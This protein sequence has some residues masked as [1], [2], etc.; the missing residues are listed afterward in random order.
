VPLALRVVTVLAWLLPGPPLTEDDAVIAKRT[1]PVRIAKRSAA[2]VRD[3]GK[4]A[5]MVE[6]KREAKAPG[7]V[8][9]ET[10]VVEPAVPVRRRK[11]LA[12]RSD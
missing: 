7:A 4:A 10:A 5:T 6:L 11:V 2:V 12:V 8:S 1:V 9:K 3:G